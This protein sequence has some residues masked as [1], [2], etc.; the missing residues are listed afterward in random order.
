MILYLKTFATAPWAG[1]GWIALLIVVF[2]VIMVATALFRADVLAFG[3][4]LGEFQTLLDWKYGLF[5]VFQQTITVSIFYWLQFHGLMSPTAA[6]IVTSI[7]FGAIGHF[8]NRGLQGWTMALALAYLSIW[9]EYH[10]V[11]I[12]WIGHFFL[13]KVYRRFSPATYNEGM[14]VWAK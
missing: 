12:L 14:R 13:S 11:Y 9:Q 3:W 5:V 4:D 8:G 2:T 7:L 10:N 6:L 1:S